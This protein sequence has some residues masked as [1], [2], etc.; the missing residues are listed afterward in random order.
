MKKIVISGMI[1]NALEWY[2]FALYAHFAGII[3]QLYFPSD[4]KFIS[5]VLTFG[6]FAAGF[7][8]RPL[9]GIVFGY[10]GDKFGRK[11]SL[12]TSIVL[13]AVPTTCIGL[14]PTYEQIGIVAP[15]LLTII[16]LLQGLSLGGG[17][18][19]CI[20]FIVEHAPDGRR[21]LIGSASV[22]SMSAGILFG[23]IVATFISHIL[24]PHD[25]NSWGWRVPFLVSAIWGLIAI[26]IRGN[27]HESPKYN[28]AKANGFLS[29]SPVREVLSNYL[30]ELLIAIGIYLTVTVPFYTL[31]IFMNNYMSQIL[32]HSIKEALLMN[33]V[34]ILVHMLFLPFASNLSDKIGRKPVLVVNSLA[35]MFLTYP[36]FWLL[37]QNGF[38]LPLMG[39]VMFGIIL[40][41]YIAPVPAL[42][43]E[44]FPTS[45]RFTGIALS[46]NLSAAIFGGTT[47][48]VAAWLIRYTNMNDALAFYI[49]LFAIIS[50][51]TLYYFRDN[52]DKPLA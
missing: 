19:G 7:V 12:V 15:I 10:I 8:M 50:L 1:G 27:I 21:G 40:S 26:Y 43:V 14:L 29:K 25:F 39:Q 16:R 42:L 36:I 49:I 5:L 24:S 6:V 23:L 32:G 11:V 28:E 33:V 52:Y 41:F 2:D 45:V 30:P 4:D 38:V 18:S 3:S 34:S 31:M 13:M 51:I 35:F 44:L 17:F 47:P 20:A 46:Y 37:C 9:G 22:F 48:M